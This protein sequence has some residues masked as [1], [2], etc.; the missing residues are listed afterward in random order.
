[1][2]EHD[3]EAESE[4]RQIAKE[5]IE[6]VLPPD[7]EDPNG[8]DHGDGHDLEKLDTLR[9]TKSIAETLSLPH[10]ILFVAIVC[11]AQLT[12]QVS[13]GSTL[14]IIHVI[15]DSFN[16]TNP[17]DLSWLIAGYSLTVGS[18]ILISGRF[19]DMFGYKRMLIIGFAWFSVWSMIAGLAVYSNHVLFIFARVFSG[20]GPAI[21]LPN[22]VAL[23][24]ATYAPGRRKAMVFALFGA[25]APGGA[26]VGA[27]FAGLFALGWVRIGLFF[28]L[29]DSV[30]LI[31]P[32]LVHGIH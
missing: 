5:T 32:S 28:L 12:T 16:L 26:I 9:S 23:L 22:G 2:A 29:S 10:E 15:G 18:F 27:A 17:G 20:I 13:L 24:G 31:Y 4:R 11:L 21:T 6:N 1:M 3:V 30:T 8:E 14:N 19:G 25:T 7:S